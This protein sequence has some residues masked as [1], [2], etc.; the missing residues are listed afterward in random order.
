V[1]TVT[2]IL[3]LNDRNELT[4]EIEDPG[5]VRKFNERD[6]VGY[7]DLASKQ[8]ESK[9]NTDERKEHGPVGKGKRFRADD[10]AG[11]PDYPHPGIH[12]FYSKNTPN[13]DDELVFK[14]ENGKLINFVIEI[15]PDPEL[16][17]VKTDPGFNP[18]QRLTKH[19]L[20]DRTTPG[21]FPFE[22]HDLMVIN[23]AATQPLKL[24]RRGGKPDEDVV[25]QHYYKFSAKVMGTNITLDPHIEIHDA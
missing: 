17:F 3:K 11:E 2:V 24:K 18:S 14:G 10:Y 25:Q 8:K 16:Y 6:A 5:Q 1:A 4:S 21:H 15:T 22:P 7:S 20:R 12:L 19:E 13:D 23:G 9:K